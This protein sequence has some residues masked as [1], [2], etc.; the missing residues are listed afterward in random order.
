MTRQP[1]S[2]TE[3]RPGRPK[4][5]LQLPAFWWT[6]KRSLPNPHPGSQSAG[7]SKRLMRRPRGTLCAALLLAC[8]PWGV[9]AAEAAGL[10]S[11][12]DGAVPLRQTPERL[13]SE[14]SFSEGGPRGEAA[15]GFAPSAELRSR[16]AA[17]DFG[18]LAA[19]RSEA[20]Q[21]RPSNLR[22]NL[23]ADAE[24]EAV[25]ERT[26]PTLTGHTLTGRLAG[27][28]LSTVVLAVNGDYIAGT[29]WSPDGMHDIRT[30]GAGP[31]VIRQLDPAALGRCGVGEAPPA[32]RPDASPAPWASGSPIAGGSRADP[33]PQAGL[34]VKNAAQ[35]DDGSLIDVLV[36]YVAGTRIPHGG[37]RAMR[38]II[39]RDVA[40][41]NEAYR[42]SGAEQRIALVGAVEV[43]WPWREI[44]A[45]HQVLNFLEGKGDGYLEEVHALRDLYAADL[46][47]L[48][49]G[50]LASWQGGSG[51]GIAF[52]TSSPAGNERLAFSIASSA[53]FAHELG[54]GMGLSHER[55]YDR[56]NEPFPYSHGYRFWATHPNW[57]EHE[58]S[59]I[60]AALLPTLP[61][62]SNPRQKW[63]DE[64]G[65]PLGVPGD[66]PSDRADG[67]ADAVR[68]LNEMR[69]AIANYRA[70]ATRCEYALS[71]ELP[72][73][74]AE[75]GEFKLRVET[76]PGCEWKARSDGGFLS[77]AEGSSGMGGGEVVYR[78]PANPG[79]E[80]EAAVLVAAEVYLVRQEGLRPVA[81]VC[82]RTGDVQEAIVAALGKTCA[83]VSGG[84]LASLG[85]LRV[86]PRAKSLKAGDFDGLSSLG[87]L[88][89]SRER[90]WEQK[91]TDGLI[92]ESGLFD[93]LSG[94]R[95]LNLERN[96]ISALPPGLFKDLHELHDLDLRFN[97]LANLKPGLFDGLSSLRDLNLGG[98]NLS[99]LQLGLFDGLTELFRLYLY[100]NQLTELPMGVFD[101]LPNLQ[102]LHLNHNSLTT[103]PA[104]LFNGPSR[105]HTLYLNYNS[106]TTLPAALFNGLSSL[107]FVGADNNQLA[108]LP[109]NLFA[110]LPLDSLWLDRNRLTSLPPGL[111]EGVT[112]LR[113]LELSENP[114]APFALRLELVAPPAPDS[115][116]GRSATVV[117][118]VA[119][120][121][122]FDVRVGLS[123][124]GGTL[125]AHS[126]L[127]E[128]GQTRGSPIS[129]APQGDGP[130]RV[131][132]DAVSGVLKEWE[133]DNVSSE[134]VVLNWRRCYRGV[135]TAA[136]PPL[137][138]FG[139]PDQTLG[140]DDTAKFH[141]PSAFPDFGD[142]A[143]YTVELSDPAV[144][145]AT[146]RDGLL[147]VS[148]IGGGK[149]TVTVTAAGPGGR[150]EMRHFSVTVLWPPE[151][152]D[153]IPDLSL[154]VGE[155]IQIEVSDNFRNSDGG[156]LTYA[157]ESSDSR[158]AV[159]SMDEGRLHIAG[160]EPGVTVVTLTT[161]D[162]DGLS[163]TLT[164]R[165]TVVRVANSYWSGWRS[166][167]LKSPSSADGDG[168]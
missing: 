63:S 9:T 36:V 137:V 148:A 145:E 91:P 34:Q 61:R 8:L 64:S 32:P 130:V 164:F 126:I 50:D 94:L 53:A 17:I 109:P 48:H 70:S 125:S 30:L 93:G 75:G 57:G 80:R 132:L 6:S 128:A 103:L 79:W 68:S 121:V 129:V 147:I 84:D 92:L 165:V 98:N 144:A 41:T 162:P 152:V 160:R 18:Q 82:E 83:D 1:V 107:W 42:E 65:V 31:A 5:R 69:R 142:R 78:A 71:S 14:G 90:L 74:P 141:L 97:Q 38:A 119:S 166:V 167:L 26:E 143:S 21:R 58:W 113:I 106:L 46:V 151:V 24:F 56:S 49:T 131:E 100:R 45:S 153:S 19:A 116:P 76:A 140:P 28:P 138:L 156:L 123:A 95:Y 16:I 146:I 118:E 39:D 15:G 163:A 77:I 40:M 29:V 35:A 66:E 158:V 2:A 4:P 96:D 7:F 52:G 3:M 124:S 86:V 111:F 60:M 135:R 44:H 54:H 73:L 55:Q 11:A 115:S 157:A 59:T 134:D 20:V 155:R 105:L 13:R 112:K 43:D 67:P 51:G 161:T 150:R 10:F 159:A 104:A 110:G 22:L 72:V 33:A 139:L 149:T 101:G 114:G 168:S 88:H 37:H 81:P 87:W 12:D 27:D 122:P 85:T 127:L 89:I 62:F 108:T 133:C 25:I 117:A 99:N 120:G 47:V 154:A 136:G 23:F 102:T